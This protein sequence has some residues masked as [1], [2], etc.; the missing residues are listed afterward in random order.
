VFVRASPGRSRVA[1]R[2]LVGGLAR[3]APTSGCG[4]NTRRSEEGRPRGRVARL[5]PVGVCTGRTWQ[6]E[7][8]KDEQRGSAA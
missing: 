2:P 6:E 3:V 1:A 8:D 4:C 5:T 7:P